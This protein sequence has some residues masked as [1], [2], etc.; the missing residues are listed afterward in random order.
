M[1]RVLL[2]RVLLTVGMLALVPNAIG[3]QSPSEVDR[4]SLAEVMAGADTFSEKEGDPPVFKAYRIDPQGG[5][6][7]LVGYVFLTSD[8]PPEPYG[9]S[10]TIEALVGMDLEGSITGIKVMRYRE[11][12]RRFR[13]DFLSARGFQEQFTGKHIAEPFMVG[14]DVA[15]ITRATITVNALSRGIR[16]SA[17]RVAEAYLRDEE[18][19]LLADRSTVGAGNAVAELAQMS[20]PQMISSGLVTEMVIG[21][22]DETGLQLSFAYMGDEAIGSILLGSRGYAVAL[23]E[24]GGSPEEHHL[25]L[26]GIDG[27]MLNWFRPEA[28]TVLQGAGVF[29]L[30]PDDV[31]V[32]GEPLE[33]KIGGQV[34]YVGI[35]LIS[36]AVDVT[37][38]FT[39]RYDVRLGMEPF[40]QEYSL[41]AGVLALIRERSAP[42]LTQP[43][44]TALQPASN[45]EDGP[46]LEPVDPESA[47]ATPQSF[48]GGEDPLG[49]SFSLVEEE[50]V[51]ARM[52]TGVRWYRVGALL[53]LFGLV[54]YAFF[55]K[56]T[57]VRWV[58]LGITLVYMGFVDGSFLSVSHITSGL[59]LGP[60]VY[61]ENI[62]VL[63]VVGFTVV[64]TLLW[65]RIF[66]GFM[67][68]F[69]AL[70][71]FL[72]A[73]V[74]R[75]FQFK[76]P[77]KIHERALY[78]KYGILALILGLALVWA[79]GSVMQYFEPFGTVFYLSPSLLLW[80]IAIGTLVVS[81]IVPRF[82][83]RYA[84]P[85][86]AALGLASLLSPFRIG[87]VEQCDVCKVCEQSCPTGAIKGPSI[88]F[89]ECVR[90]NICE[91]K[92][93]T[94]AGTC[95]HDMD[96]IR[97]RLVQ[98]NTRTV[99]G[100]S[101][102]SP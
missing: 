32:L 2:T 57:G 42:S 92:L 10:G 5:E 18:P 99:A 43:T 29:P 23:D 22:E 62:T 81:A 48:S 68:P 97:P 26:L 16:N 39:I 55:R 94:R 44:A 69:G 58:A 84:C 31:I 90:C 33:G 66:C 20:W 50:T 59:T 54:M 78:I 96:E 25:M 79:D 21:T 65:G 11:T 75:R 52:F 28:F 67:C 17:R 8:L 27:S 91:I 13:G 64:T 93:L 70:Q 86:G 30:S 60:A 1:T 38:P 95:G 12:L 19:V 3:A 4:T 77:R 45:P 15:G 80:A 56:S 14:R 88:D 9:Y 72:E 87:R 37:E 83:C 49:L 98:L 85:L 41:P 101:L 89:K 35:M 7:T 34:Q 71:D 76:M 102:G 53:S 82:Y 63:L 100:V 36:R 6:R 51:L 61:L 74:P 47:P 24:A 73:A 46:V 40:S